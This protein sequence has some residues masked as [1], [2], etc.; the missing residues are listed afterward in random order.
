MVVVRLFDAV[1]PVPAQPDSALIAITP[2][3]RTLSM[4]FMEFLSVLIRQVKH[5]GSD[6]PSKNF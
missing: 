5:R 1:L 3:A 4:R 6:K 2:S